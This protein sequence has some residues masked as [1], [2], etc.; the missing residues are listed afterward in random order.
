MGDANTG[1]TRPL[2]TSISWSPLRGVAVLAALLLVSTGPALFRNLNRLL[3]SGPSGAFV[4][5]VTGKYATKGQGWHLTLKGAPRL[6]TS[7]NAIDVQVSG[8]DYDDVPLGDSV[9]VVVKSGFFG[10]P[11]IVSYRV[12]TPQD[13]IHELLERH[14]ALERRGGN[15]LPHP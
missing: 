5:L 7:N 3:D 2:A 14:H 4:G 15:E 10:R 13:R 11:W 12:Q 1:T 9:F 6:P 8:R